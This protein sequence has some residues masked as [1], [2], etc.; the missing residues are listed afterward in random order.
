VVRQIGS[1]LR[2]TGGAAIAAAKAA[3][4]PNVWSGRAS[5]EVF[6]EPISMPIVA[7]VEFALLDMA[8]LRLIIAP[9]QHH[10]PVGRSTAGP[11]H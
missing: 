2:S 3:Y 9:Y 7:T 11:F 5:Q 4:D 6:I 10:S 1:G 8:M